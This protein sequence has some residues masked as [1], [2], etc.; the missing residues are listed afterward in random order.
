VVQRFPRNERTR[1]LSNTAQ[2]DQNL[3]LKGT[4]RWLLCVGLV[5]SSLCFKGN[6][7]VACRSGLVVL[8]KYEA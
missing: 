6:S 1:C 8:H 3:G 5:E 4:F 7:V 2:R